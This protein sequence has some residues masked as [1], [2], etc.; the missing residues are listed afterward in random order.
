MNKV[1][2]FLCKVGMVAC[3]L[4]I[5]LSAVRGWEK[6]CLATTLG[7]ASLLFVFPFLYSG[8]DG[9]PTLKHPSNNM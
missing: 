6:T 3:G 9:N 8:R 4:L 2:L 7:F 1:W 5:I